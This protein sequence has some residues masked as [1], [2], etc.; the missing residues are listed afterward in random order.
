[1]KGGASAAKEW[2]G[3]KGTMALAK[4]KGRAA[5]VWDSTARIWRGDM[6]NVDNFLKVRL[7]ST[8]GSKDSKGAEER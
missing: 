2:V 4:G 3:E 7:A 6:D 1:M 8:P 5:E